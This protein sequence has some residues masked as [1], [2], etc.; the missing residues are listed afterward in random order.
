MYSH[1]SL[2]FFHSYSAINLTELSLRARRLKKKK[3]KDFLGGQEFKKEKESHTQNKQNQIP[4]LIGSAGANR[5]WL[6]FSLGISLRW[7][8]TTRDQFEVKSYNFLTSLNMHAV[9]DMIVASEFFHIDACD[10]MS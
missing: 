9:L 6:A 5:Q 3:F 8:L 10:K 7:N 1:L 2:Y 4:L